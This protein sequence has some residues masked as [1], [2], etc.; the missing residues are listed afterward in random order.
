MRYYAVTTDKQIEYLLKLGFVF[1]YAPTSDLGN[2][3]RT[4]K[5]NDGEYYSRHFL[6]GVKFWLEDIKK[7][8]IN[9]D[10]YKTCEINNHCDENNKYNDWLTKYVV[11][12]DGGHS[13]SHKYGFKTYND[14]LDAAITS[15]LEYLIKNQ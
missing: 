4:F 5:G 1:Q 15:A 10:W 9:V 11:W 6:D 14:G 12:N 7:I 8:R 3:D 13:T 2:N